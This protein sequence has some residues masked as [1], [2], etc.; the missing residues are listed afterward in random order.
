[1][2]LSEMS[3]RVLFDCTLKGVP[4]LECACLLGVSARGVPGLRPAS[5][6]EEFRRSE[7]TAGPSPLLTRARALGLCWASAGSSG[8]TGEDGDAGQAERCSA[9][10]LCL[11]EF[12]LCARTRD[13]L[14]ERK[15]SA[16]SQNRTRWSAPRTSMKCM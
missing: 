5:V 6:L 11:T 9:K 16:S 1:M 8:Q 13:Q 10:E 14:V 12:R 4:V 2:S 3:R 15:L 7:C